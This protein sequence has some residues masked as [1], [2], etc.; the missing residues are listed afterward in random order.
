MIRHNNGT[1]A[2]SAVGHQ[3]HVTITLHAP[4][5][6]RVLIDATTKGPVTIAA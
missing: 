2:C 3:R 6:R 4:L 1:A 5:S